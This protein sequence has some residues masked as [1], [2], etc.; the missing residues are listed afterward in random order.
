MH[1][2]VFGA[3]MPA[4]TITLEQGES[5]YTQ[6]GGMAWMSDGISMETNM[7]G[8]LFKGIG[9][10]FAG[11]SLF[12][13]TYSAMRPGVEITL[14]SSFPGEIRMLEL[15]K[16]KE[17]IAQKNS[18]LCATPGVNLGAYVTGVKT[19]L[20]GGEGFVLQR[21]SGQGLAFLELDGTIVEKELAPGEKIKVD[22]GNIAFFE[23]SVGYSAE[24]VKGFANILFGGEGLF[25]STL[26][27]PGK[28]WL[29][30]MSASELARRIVPFLP[31]GHSS[32]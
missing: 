12:M 32:N 30:T 11:E 2:R 6:S 10:M 14:A 27:G 31:A 22:T 25:L 19:G 16:G 29:Q 26:T 28:V 8:G 5:I 24:M 23:A 21:Y 4:V 1:Y 18:F 15:G 3:P 7:H 9:R 13:A 17:Y 20:F